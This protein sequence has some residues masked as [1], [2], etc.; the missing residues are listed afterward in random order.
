MYFGTAPGRGGRTDQSL[1]GIREGRPGEAGLLIQRDSAGNTVAG[2]ADG[3]ALHGGLLGGCQRRANR[4]AK[5]FGDIL[6]KLFRL[7]FRREAARHDDDKLIGIVQAVTHV[8]VAILGRQNHIFARF[9]RIAL[10]RPVRRLSA[11]I[12]QGCGGLCLDVGLRVVRLDDGRERLDRER[13]LAPGNRIWNSAA[14]LAGFC[15]SGEMDSTGSR[16]IRGAGECF[17]SLYR[18]LERFGRPS[19][20]QCGAA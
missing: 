18:M 6:V 17:G 15:V 16:M 2:Y 1:S 5:R 14:T 8:R 9:V 13:L 3:M 10:R 12:Q 20:W 11:V 7:H 4:R 19:H